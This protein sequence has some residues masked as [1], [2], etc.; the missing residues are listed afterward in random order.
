[1]K[2]PSLRASGEYSTAFCAFGA[3]PVIDLGFGFGFGLTPDTMAVIDMSVLIPIKDTQ[4]SVTGQFS[5]PLRLLNT[6]NCGVLLYGS[7]LG[8]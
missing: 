2:L 8:N 5:F 1:M 3:V 7:L 6:N 4:S